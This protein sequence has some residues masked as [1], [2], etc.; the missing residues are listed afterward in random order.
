MIGPGCKRRARKGEPFSPRSLKP[1]A[2]KAGPRYILGPANPAV[3]PAGGWL[4][5][6]ADEGRAKLRKAR[7]RRK[8]PWNPGSPN[9]ISCPFGDAPG[10]ER[11]R[12]E[13]KHPS[14]RRK[15]KQTRCR[16]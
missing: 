13:R 8:E 11:E 7:G 15:R 10:R 14:T 3:I 16:E 12:G 1:V 4:G 2:G 6:G 5:S 9:G